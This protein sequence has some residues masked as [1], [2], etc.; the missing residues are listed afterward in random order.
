M[1]KQWYYFSLPTSFDNRT[2]QNFRVWSSW[3]AEHNQIQS[4]VLFRQ[5]LYTSNSV[6]VTHHFVCSCS[7]SNSCCKWIDQGI[8]FSWIVKRTYY[9]STLTSGRSGSFA[10]LSHLTE[11]KFVLRFLPLI[12]EAFLWRFFLAFYN[13]DQGIQF[14]WIVKRTYFYFILGKKRIFCQ[15][16]SF[17]GA[18]TCTTFPI[19][20]FRGFSLVLFSHILQFC[21][22]ALTQSTPVWKCLRTEL[23][24]R[25]DSY[26]QN[27]KKIYYGLATSKY[28]P[29]TDMV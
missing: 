1:A 21:Q 17:D 16:F 26:Q 10:S 27:A 18:K 3:I 20:D 22:R 2:H 9:I 7:L 4:K 6:L 23:N 25:T 24:V 19:S 29:T 8:K 28:Q 5:T 15:F 12:S 13:F 14:I 11:P